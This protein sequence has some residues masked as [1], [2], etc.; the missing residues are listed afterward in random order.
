L[1][2]FTREQ[3]VE[4]ALA[5]YSED[6]GT[7][8]G[9]RVFSRRTDTRQYPYYQVVDD[10]VFLSVGGVPDTDRDRLFELVTGLSDGT[11]PRYFD[12]HE[13]LRLAFGP[14]GDVDDIKTTVWTAEETRSLDPAIRGLRVWTQGWTFGD[15]RTRMKSPMVFE[16]AEDVDLGRLRAYLRDYDLLSPYDWAV[17]ATGRIAY[18]TGTVPTDEYDGFL[19]GTPPETYTPPE[20]REREYTPAPDGTRWSFDTDYDSETTTITYEA[21]PP[22]EM[23]NSVGVTLNNDDIFAN[24]DQ[25]RTNYEAPLTPGA[26]VTVTTPPSLAG[27]DI[28]ISWM[29]DEPYFVIRAY[30]L[31]DPSD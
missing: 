25:F 17:T 6:L 30:T 29:V 21:G 12:N 20:E 5:T 14:L 24:E 19:P 31:P 27:E 1:G 16:S 8:D 28:T 9:Y 15:D 2:S 13:R 23:L 3:V 10:G 18:L 7:R 11:V 26:S 22:I 4:A